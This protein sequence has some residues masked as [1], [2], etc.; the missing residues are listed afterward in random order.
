VRRT[1][2]VSL[3]GLGL[4]LG[5]LVWLWGSPATMPLRGFFPRQAAPEAAFEQAF[6]AVP[7]PEVA[8]EDL[9]N[10]TAVPRVAGTA[11]DYAAAR[12]V[13]EVFQK[14]GLA[15]EIVEYR[16][17][18]PMPRE[19]K[20]DLVAP[21]RR[22]GPTRE[23]VGTK[24]GPDRKAVLGF[25]A[26]SPS[27]DVTALVVYANYGLPEDYRRLEQL[28]ID[29][30]GK[31]VLVRYG[32]C[33]RGVKAYV[34]E[35]HHAAGLLIYSDP[36]EDGFRRGD[37]YPSGPWRPAT[38][39]QRG[40]I[41][42]MTK[43]AGDPLTPGLPATRDA[44]R[45]ALQD[46]STL[47]RVP[48]AP[49]SSEDAAPILKN[50]G[51]QEVPKD[52]QGGLPFP[53]H[54]GPG[55]AKV[56]LRLKMDFQVRPI[57]NVIARID[58]ASQPE[59]W[60]IVGNHR[61]AW[62][63]GAV[64]PLSGTT[65]LL[66]VARGLGELVRQGWKPARTV[67]LASWDGEEFGLIG[68]TEW[69][70]EHASELARRAVAYLNTDVAVGGGHFQASAVPSLRGLLREVAR[71]VVDPKT[72]KPLYNVWREESVKSR[73]AKEAAPVVPVPGGHA[74]AEGVNIGELGAGSDYVS[75][76][77]HLGVPSL[78]LGFVGPYG[79]Y[80]SIYDNF[81]WMEHFGDPT[82][83][84]NVVAAQVLG[85]LAL[86][87]ANADILPLDYEEY[88]GAMQGY[89]DSLEKETA[90][91]KQG[92]TPLPLEQV[93]AATARFSTAARRLN[94]KIKDATE[95]GN[96]AVDRLAALNQA[97]LRVERGF[98]LEPGL[99]GRDWFRHAFYAP[100]V[101]TGYAAV[102]LPGV[103]EALDRNDAKG[104]AEQLE[105]VRAAIDRGTQ[106]LDEALAAA[107]EAPGGEK[108]PQRSTSE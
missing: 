32:K 90:G 39:I 15:P 26:Y 41:L 20:V 62:T 14:A 97:L 61:D 108:A 10:L 56:H 80:H 47:P 46:V 49:I 23:G 7:T 79:V 93:R 77:Q 72:E 105:Q 40:S 19:V 75:F 99:P 12:Y 27:G 83:K 9:H 96:L 86:R 85:T 57:W 34:A 4:T 2:R 44:K 94:E 37:V 59:N 53:Y 51:G 50:L 3:G 43:Y 52:W 22:S 107:G 5:S 68:S 60:V 102:V 54:L 98:L 8:R 71:E 88:A 18:L 28:G 64:D 67:I 87:L 31:L 84:Y 58:G 100:G 63:Y 38:A 103:R 66:A 65:C 25:N 24:E 74:G 82:F 91:R 16:V 70:E 17:L 30:A 89:L 13:F 45:L 92:E 35:E 78:D 33:F 104:A 76:L 6:R 11:E 1:S 73:S 48:T 81:Y 106:A 29:V 55:P 21:F 95:Q 69:A 42:Y 101:Y 36:A